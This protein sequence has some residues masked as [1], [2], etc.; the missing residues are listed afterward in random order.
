[1]SMKVIRERE[2]AFIQKGRSYESDCVNGQVSA[3]DRCQVF[4]LTYWSEPG[5]VSRNGTWFDRDG[6]ENG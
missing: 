3:M 2:K 4:V 5:T 1:M 6:S